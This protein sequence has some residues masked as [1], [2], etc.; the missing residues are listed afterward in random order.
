[1]TAAVYFDH[2][3]TTPVDPRV[4]EAMVPVFH[5]DFANA[6]S[7]HAPG[8]RA[9]GMVEEGRRRLA[10]LLGAPPEG[11]YFTSGG[12]ES[13]NWAVKGMAAARTRDKSHC[14]VSAVEHHAVLHAAERLKRLGVEVELIPV[15]AVGRV[16]PEEVARRIRPTTFLVSVMHANNE[17][18]TI[19]PI[20][21]IGKDPRWTEAVAIRLDM[22]IPRRWAMHCHTGEPGGDSRTHNQNQQRRQTPRRGIAGFEAPLQIPGLRQSRRVRLDLNEMRARVHLMPFLNR[23]CPKHN[24]PVLAQDGSLHTSTV[25]SQPCPPPWISRG[26]F[27]AAGRGTSPRR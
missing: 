9:R 2:A 12:T 24:L 16:E 22:D 5:T 4:V 15:D 18:G 20:A 23:R 26:S 14:L 3:A 8:E 21:A 27:Q 19:Q 6:S 25:P 10:D 1:M 7:S 11:I 17:V 13:D